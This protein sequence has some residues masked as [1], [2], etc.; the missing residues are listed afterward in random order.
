MF[1][2]CKTRPAL[3][4]KSETIRDSQITAS[5]AQ[6]SG[7]AWLARV[8]ISSSGKA[9]GWVARD[10]VVDSWIQVDLGGAKIVT[11]KRNINI[12]ICIFISSSSLSLP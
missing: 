9:G 3:G 4:M 5:S 12:D 2:E 1:A 10:C 8:D 7:E 11:G 6:P